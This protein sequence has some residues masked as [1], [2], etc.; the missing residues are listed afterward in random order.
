MDYTS[1]ILQALEKCKTID[2]VIEVEEAI[3]ITSQI[4]RRTKAG[5]ELT[6]ELL[7]LTNQKADI[8]VSEGAVPF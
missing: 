4:N 6:Q 8:L 3:K 7:T 1:K 2:Q 5:R